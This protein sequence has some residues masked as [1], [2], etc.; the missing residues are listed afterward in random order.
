MKCG[1]N[2]ILSD[3]PQQT[4]PSEKLISEC[5]P[6]PFSIRF[7]FQMHQ[8]PDSLLNV[9]RRNESVCGSELFVSPQRLRGCLCMH[10]KKQIRIQAATYIYEQ[11]DV[12]L[13]LNLQCGYAIYKNGILRAS[14]ES[15]TV[16]ASHFLSWG[17]ELKFSCCQICETSAGFCC[18]PT[19]CGP[20]AYMPR[21]LPPLQV[22]CRTSHLLVSG[23]WCSGTV[24]VCRNC[25]REDLLH[26]DESQSCHR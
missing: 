3:A 21:P 14:A 1:P 22:K 16:F 10:F 25:C 8:L 4:L 24:P 2:Y 12:A 19:R 6:Q 17:L 13:I 15:C 11:P 7:H 18:P 5:P 9:Q 23:L 26:C 20:F